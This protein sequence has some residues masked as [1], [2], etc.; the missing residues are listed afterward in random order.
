MSAGSHEP[1]GPLSPA[2]TMPGMRFGAHLPLIGWP[3]RD[4]D[5]RLV[6][7]VAARAET[8]GYSVLAANDH[9]V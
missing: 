8:L 3:G 9:L 5:P 1:D 2:A 6:L 4:P 7:E